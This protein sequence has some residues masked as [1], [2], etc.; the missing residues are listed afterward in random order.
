MS[1][2]CE[3]AR[4]TSYN[5]CYTKLLRAALRRKTGRSRFRQHI[6][7]RQPCVRILF[8]EE[9]QNGMPD[10]PDFRFRGDH[11]RVLRKAISDPEEVAPHGERTG[12]PRLQEK[13][14]RADS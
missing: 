2:V 9:V 1:A 5:V 8:V 14:D 6:M 3:Y 13:R 10:G 4:I 12:F 7:Q 11:V